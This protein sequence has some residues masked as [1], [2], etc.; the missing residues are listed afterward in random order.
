MQ[1]EV[2][3]EWRERRPEPSKQFIAQLA[4]TETS[5]N[6]FPQE[7]CDRLLYRGWWLAGATLSQYHRDLLPAEL[8]FRPDPGA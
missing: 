7:I 1:E 5:F 2:A 8:P 6:Q 3:A 4:N